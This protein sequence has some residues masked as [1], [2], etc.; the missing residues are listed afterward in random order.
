MGMMAGSSYL[1]VFPMLYSVSIFSVVMQVCKHVHMKQFQF[2]HFCNWFLLQSQGC[3]QGPR[4]L[5]FFGKGRSKRT[6]VESPSPTGLS[7]AG[8]SNR[9]CKFC[10]LIPAAVS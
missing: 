2:K 8:Q 1:Q 3:S 6:V 9:M 7:V 4:F 10:C 5:F